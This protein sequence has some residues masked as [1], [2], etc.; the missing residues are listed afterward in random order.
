[1]DI[2]FIFRGRTD[3]KRFTLG[4]RL[5]RFLIALRRFAAW[6][7]WHVPTQYQ[8]ALLLV[9]CKVRTDAKR[10][11]LGMRLERFLV[12]F[13]GLPPCFVAIIHLLEFDLIFFLP[14][15]GSSDLGATMPH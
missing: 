7:R 5:G 4:M 12:A 3:S 8:A 14:H 2:A 1:M 11:T 6:F 13:A 9:Q 15:L 10:L